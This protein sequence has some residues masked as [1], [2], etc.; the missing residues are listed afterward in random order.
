VRPRARR[1]APGGLGLQTLYV[2]EHGF[3]VDF[4]PQGRAGIQLRGLREDLAQ[5]PRTK[6]REENPKLQICR[7]HLDKNYEFR[8][9]GRGDISIWRLHRYGRKGGL[10]R[11]FRE[12]ESDR[13]VR[14]QKLGGPV[15]KWTSPRRGNEVEGPS[16]R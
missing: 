7:A 15:S 16:Q 10:L 4:R 14:A 8:Y 12:R 3:T 1:C 11:G 13:E 2:E 9:L 5:G 6:A